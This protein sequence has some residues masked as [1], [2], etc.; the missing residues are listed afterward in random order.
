[1]NARTILLYL[2]GHAGAIRAV[3]ESR[4]AFVT[5]LVLVLITTIPRNYDQTFIGESPLRWVLG[6][7]VF[8]VVSG[9]WLYCIAYCHGV[10]VHLGDSEQ[11]RPPYWAGWRSFMGLFWMTAPVAWLYALPVERYLESI[12]AVKVNLGLLA[13]VALWRV[14]LMVRVFQVICWPPWP[15]TVLWVLTAAVGEVLVVT[16][17]GGGVAKAILAGMGGMRN[18][19]EEEIVMS[20]LAGATVVS[21]WVFPIL[22]LITS[23]LNWQ[24]HCEVIDFP[25]RKADSVRWLPLGV[26]AA[27]WLA[28]AV[29]P[30][31]QVARNATADRLAAEG[32]FPELIAYL[33]A[34]QPGD[35]APAR[36]LPPKPFEVEVF[37]QLPQCF[38]ALTPE[39]AP[40]VRQHF[41]K[42]LD[43][44]ASHYTGRWHTPNETQRIQNTSD[45]ISAWGRRSDAHDFKWIVEGLANTPEGRAWVRTNLLL[46]PA[47]ELQG[48]E[49]SIPNG[50]VSPDV[51]KQ[52]AAWNSV[53]ELLAR[54]KLEATN[55][56]TP[57]SAPQQ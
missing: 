48:R 50:N 16:L 28:V 45:A 23:I 19:P 39:A 9:S 49:P 29:Y 33:S 57:P 27:G 13:I 44:F 1:M 20:V 41:M 25:E 51:V 54:I 55:T 14:V 21:F 7:L 15:M 35:F 37:K 30:Q 34:H 36:Q 2:C 6:S 32:K 3:A 4:A 42:R 24:M 22:A 56:T 46:I 5:G 12:G 26:A 17:F 52:R 31:T 38:K 11:T 47:L 18:S 8:S 40:W 53:V 43:E 10:R